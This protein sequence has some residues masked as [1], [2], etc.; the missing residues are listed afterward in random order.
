MGVLRKARYRKKDS[1]DIAMIIKVGNEQD[2]RVIAGILVSN[3]YTVK[4]T[5]IKVKNNTKVVL[6]VK[7]ESED[8]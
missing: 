3:G 6:E 4:I 5:R 1:G 8:K 7:E 2:R